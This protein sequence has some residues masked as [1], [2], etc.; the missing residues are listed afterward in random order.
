MLKVHD[1]AVA[2][3][4]QEKGPTLDELAREGDASDADE[5]PGRGGDAGHRG[6]R[7][8]P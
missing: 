8:G 5:S 3:E 6:P 1:N 2:T 4:E 7:H